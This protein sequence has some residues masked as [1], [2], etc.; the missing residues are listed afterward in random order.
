MDAYLVARPRRFVTDVAVEAVGGTIAAVIVGW[1]GQ[2]PALVG[3]VFGAIFASILEPRAA[4]LL[5]HLSRN[6][7]PIA[8][9]TPSAREIGRQ[10]WRPYRWWALV[11]ATAVILVVVVVTA[12]D[13]TRGTS[14][15]GGRKT[16]FIP[17]QALG[18]V[19]VPDVRGA[20]FDDARA[21]LIARGF[22]AARGSRRFDDEIPRGAVAGTEPAAA[23]AV[24]RRSRVEIVVSLGKG[25]EVPNVERLSFDEASTQL[26][27]QG[28]AVTR[29]PDRFDDEV[30]QGLVLRTNPSAGETVEHGSKVQLAV[31]LGKGIEVPEVRGASLDDAS[32]ELRA[33]GFDIVRRPDRLDAEVPSGAVVGTD[34]A[35]G[36]SVAQASEV[37]I[38]VSLG[39]GSEVPDVRGALFDDASA[40]LAAE[41]F[42]VVRRDQPDPT[43]P[44]GTVIST[45]PGAGGVVPEGTTVEVLVSQGAGL[46]PP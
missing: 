34:P 30:P 46:A 18:Y 41:G 32:A 6:R 8:V 12:I 15:L 2:I 31:S 36:E 11:T 5:Q 33:N 43:L 24:E 26:A 42:V 27:A 7:P 20:S 23:Q 14:V 13:V 28:F 22:V 40:E 4:G 1:L 21:R 19:E 38:V 25:V 10:R 37:Q 35:A 44:A 16:T 45:D 9:K 17:P 3:L 29:A 39:K